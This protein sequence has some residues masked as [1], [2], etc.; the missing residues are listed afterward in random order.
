MVDAS[1]EAASSG[2]LHFRIAIM[3]HLPYEKGDSKDIKEKDSHSGKE[4]KVS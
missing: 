3:L 1:V 2:S 4:A